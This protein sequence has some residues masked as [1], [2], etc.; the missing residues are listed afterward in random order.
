MNKRALTIAIVTPLGAAIFGNALV[1]DAATKWYPSLRKSRL[2]LPLWAFIPIGI[3]Y[4]LMCGV[5]LYRLLALVA[6]SRQRTVAIVLLLSMMGANEGWNYLFFGRKD[7]RA[8][9]LG[10]LGFI[11]LTVALYGALNRIDRRSTT[12]LR[13]YLAWLGYDVVWAY[14]LWR[15][16]T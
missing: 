13:A 12:I 3:L 2:V 10:L 9:L 5:L 8:S 11:V 1:G 4:Y 16:N 15:L 6:P 14:E 7:L